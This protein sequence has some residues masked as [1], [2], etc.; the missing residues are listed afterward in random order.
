MKTRKKVFETNSSSMHSITL[1]DKKGL[2]EPVPE[3]MIGEDNVLRINT[4]DHDFGWEIEDYYDIESKLAYAV[5]VSS[6]EK[7]Y[8][9]QLAFLLKEQTGV[10]NVIFEEG[11]SVDHQSWDL[12][13]Q[14][15]E[16]LK[17]FIFNPDSKVTTDNDNH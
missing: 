3:H 5:I 1:A 17:E 11:G 7:Q 12:N 14:I 9:S 16:N 8:R 6:Y 10:T 2:Y 13:E 4:E 15:F